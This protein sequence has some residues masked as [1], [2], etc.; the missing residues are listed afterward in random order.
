MERID[1]ISP[2]LPLLVLS[3]QLVT[4]P[5]R[6]V[7]VG[8]GGPTVVCT[9]DNNRVSILVL[10]P[11]LSSPV[12]IRPDGADLSIGIAGEQLTGRTLIHTSVYPV[13]T[14]QQWVVGSAALPVFQVIETVYRPTN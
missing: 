1:N 13:L 14:Q 7:T 2:G 6:T 11:N 5:V 9:P 10:W 3:R 8:G 12:A 4:L